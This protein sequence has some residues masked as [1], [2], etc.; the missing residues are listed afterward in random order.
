MKVMSKGS[1]TMDYTIRMARPED[2]AAAA[3]IKDE[4]LR[5]LHE[6]EAL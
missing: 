2:A 1:V 5:T 3:A 4:I 6:M